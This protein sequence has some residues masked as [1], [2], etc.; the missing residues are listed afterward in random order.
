MLSDI[1]ISD[2]ARQVLQSASLTGYDLHPAEVLT[3][4]ES[5]DRAALP[6]LWELLVVGRGGPAH[7]DSGIAKLR[8]CGECGLV[9]YSAFRNGIV[10]DPS[11]YDGSDF[12]TVVEYPK[13]V[14][15]SE[16]ARAVIEGKRLTN[17]TFID[18]T[19]LEWPH[20]VI[21]PT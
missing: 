1:V 6:K 8:E 17:A 5:I 3:T 9:E 2:H 4:P 7:K 15:V 20:G 13:Y 14:L 12:F 10:V 16:R 18:S 21:E 11:T 19:K